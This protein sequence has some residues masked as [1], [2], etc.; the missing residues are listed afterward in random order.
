[1]MILQT[2][3]ATLNDVLKV[4]HDMYYDDYGC[5]C[6]CYD[7][8]FLKDSDDDACCCNDDYDYDDEERSSRDDCCFYGDDDDDDGFLNVNCVWIVCGSVHD[9]NVLL[10]MME[11]CFYLCVLNMNCVVVALLLVNIQNL[12]DVYILYFYTCDTMKMNI[13]PWILLH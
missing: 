10:Y 12:Y 13:V 2:V 7:Y 9:G 8:D 1:M 6:C 5:C 4:Y 11:I 3:N